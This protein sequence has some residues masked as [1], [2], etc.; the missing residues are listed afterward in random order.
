M[1]PAACSARITWNGHTCPRTY[2]IQPVT[3]GCRHEHVQTR[4]LCRYHRTTAARWGHCI[5]C[6]NAGQLC[7]LTL[8]PAP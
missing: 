5:P 1:T 2:G 6:R 8:T 3:A 7:W 4:P